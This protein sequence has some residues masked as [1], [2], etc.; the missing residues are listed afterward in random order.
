[1]L[2]V[3]LP[4][5]VVLFTLTLPPPQAQSPSEDVRSVDAIVDA[6]Y[7]VIS[8]PAGKTRDWDRM[9]SLFVP[10]ARLIPTR[11]KADSPGAEARVLTVDEYI[12][13][14]G[15]VLEKSG[16]FE[17]EISRKTES[18][19]NIVQLFSTYASR[20]ALDDKEPFA[21]GINGIQL[22][23]DDDRYW[24]VTVYWDAERPAS[25]IP[26]RYLKE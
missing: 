8:G 4:L 20:R 25:P 22:L 19:G 16:F 18:F 1:M 9:R 14:S 3:P 7:D 2:P 17:K 15:P 5:T 13:R 10:G 11:P 24:I 26:E 23:K 6:L 21:R 12:E